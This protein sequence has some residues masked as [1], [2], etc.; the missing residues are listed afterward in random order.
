MLLSSI[1]R[2]LQIA[3]NAALLGALQGAAPDNGALRQFDFK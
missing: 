2:A 3:E 1:D